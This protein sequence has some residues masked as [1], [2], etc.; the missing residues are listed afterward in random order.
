M[1]RKL[2][3]T[4]NSLTVTIPPALASELGFKAGGMVELEVDRE[5][6]GLLIKRRRA[7]E[8]AEA[9]VTQ[10]FARWVDG[11]IDRYDTALKKLSGD[12]P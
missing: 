7:A 4:G 12:Q 9:P 1:E 8:P 11:F 10:E 5:H 2:F 6:E 3:R